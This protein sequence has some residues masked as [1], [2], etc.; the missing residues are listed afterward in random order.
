LVGWLRWCMNRRK[1]RPPLNCVSVRWWRLR[2][3]KQGVV[4]EFV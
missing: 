1:E 4:V 3:W 2:I